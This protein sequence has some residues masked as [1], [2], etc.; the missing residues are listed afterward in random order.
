MS[1]KVVNFVLENSKM[2]GSARLLLVV[3]ADMSNNDGECWPGKSSLARRVNVSTRQI[4]RL[5]QEC[6]RKGELRVLPPDTLGGQNHYLIIGIAPDARVRRAR[7]I[8]EKKPRIRRVDV[9]S[10]TGVSSDTRVTPLVTPVSPKPSTQPNTLKRVAPA[11]ADAAPLP[12][13]TP[14]QL[15]DLA[16]NGYQSRPVSNDVAK[17]LVMPMNSKPDKP[18]RAFP[19]FDAIVEA[20]G[21]DPATLTKTEKGGIGKVANELKAA[22]YT[23]EDILAIHAYCVRQKFESF[24]WHALTAHASKWRATQNGAAHNPSAPTGMFAGTNYDDT[25]WERQD[26]AKA[27]AK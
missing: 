3:L 22:G 1:A 10:D 4:I 2:T 13:L 12:E 21:V 15:F 25:Y 18:A 19:H 16:A 27:S 20:F 8:S 5:V 9:S 14:E 26:A 24:T 6:E 17:A 7:T 23:P 11:K